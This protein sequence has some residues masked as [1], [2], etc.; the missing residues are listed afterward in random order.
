M[1]GWTG[2][3][4]QGG[5][6]PCA[7]LPDYETYLWARPWWGFAFAFRAGDGKCRA[8]R[9]EGGGELITSSWAD[10]KR[11]LAEER[12]ERPVDADSWAGETLLA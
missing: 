11:L 3:T 10:M 12:C 4:V 5:P 7:L 8:V 1:L 2:Q 6:I 9:R